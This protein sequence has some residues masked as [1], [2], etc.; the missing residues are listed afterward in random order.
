MATAR[1]L[2]RLVAQRPMPTR[3]V[4]ASSMS[5]YG[6]GEYV[7]DEHGRVAPRPAPG[8]AA[9]RALVGGRVPDVRRRRCARSDQRGQ[10]ADP[11]VDLRDQQARP[12]GDV[13]RHRRRLRHPDRGAALL[14]RLRPGPGA[15]EPV[16][17]RRGDLRL[18]PAER[19]S[20]GHLRGRRA[21]AR[22]HARLRH[23]PGHHARARVRRAPSATRS[24]SAPAVRRPSPRSRSVISRGHRPRHRARAQRAVPR[25]RHP[26]LLRRPD[27]GARAARLRG[28]KTTSRTAWRELVEWLAG[29]GRRRPRRRATHELAARGLAR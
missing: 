4:V 5:I 17:R 28:R 8:G 10:A 18:A 23:R 19:S 26:S 9:A 3:L 27:A 24:T 29:P 20:A 22:L 25:R 13:P 7:C 15:L 21:V 2:E 12:R 11:D 14:Q 16:H 6:E 1:F